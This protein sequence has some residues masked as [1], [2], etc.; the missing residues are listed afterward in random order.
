M[1][2]CGAEV[3]FSLRHHLLRSTDVSIAL[4]AEFPSPE[5]P[6]GRALVRA[7]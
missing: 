1:K 6:H 4:S 3:S 5:N 7:Q 2:V